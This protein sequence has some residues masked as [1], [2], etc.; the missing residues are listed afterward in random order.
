ME[1]R[2]RRHSQSI[3]RWPPR[4]NGYRYDLEPTGERVARPLVPP[5]ENRYVRGMDRRAFVRTTLGAAGATCLAGGLVACDT[6]ASSAAISDSPALLASMGPDRIRRIGE[7]YLAAADGGR[8]AESLR[9]ALQKT[10][11]PWP[12]STPRTV[13]DCVRE[14]FTMNRTVVADGWLLAVTEARQCALYTLLNR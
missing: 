2:T 3:G 9:G 4:L 10:L 12:W 11:A 7:A 5:R 1:Y 14:D 8:D 13:D 6:P